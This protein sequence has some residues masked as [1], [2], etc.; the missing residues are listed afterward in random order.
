M[1]VPGDAVTTITLTAD[2]DHTTQVS[3]AFDVDRSMHAILTESVDEI[4]G[5][6]SK[7]LATIA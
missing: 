4:L 2:S 1:T 7:I 6:V 5:R 3:Y